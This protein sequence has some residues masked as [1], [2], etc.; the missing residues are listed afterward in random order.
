[1]LSKEPERKRCRNCVDE[2]AGSYLELVRQESRVN[3]G[4][5]MQLQI[6]SI[7]EVVG[8]LAIGVDMRTK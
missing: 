5:V 4:Q 1:M 2:E 6:Q 3:E 8:E 7:Q